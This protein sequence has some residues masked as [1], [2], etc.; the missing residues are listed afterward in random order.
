MSLEWAGLIGILLFLILIFFEIPVGIC[1]GV[2]GFVGLGL[3]RGWDSG[4]SV[5]GLQ[6]YR[7]AAT[8]TFSV[9]P[10]FV[11]MGFLASEIG[12]SAD[13]F[14]AVRNWLGHFKGGLAMATMVACAIFSA[15]CG[16]SIATATTLAAVGLPEMRKQKYSDVLSLGVLAS[17]G[18][19]GFLIPPSLGFVFYAIITE[20]SIGNLFL[21]G[22]GPGILLTAIFLITIAVWCRIDPH[23]GPASAPVNWNKRLISLR[24]IITPAV[25]IVWVL[26]GI[27][28][29]FVTPIEAAAAGTFIIYVI[30]IAMRR[31]TKN[32]FTNSLYETGKLTGRIFILVSGA[33]VLTRFITISELPARLAEMVSS[34]NLPP[35][36]ILWFIMIFYIII[37]FILDIMSIIL[38]VAPVLHFVLVGLGFNPVYLGAITM[39][40]ILMGQISPPFGIV[41]FGLKAFVP[42]VPV[43]TIY[44]GCLPFLGAMLIG[45]AICIHVPA[46]ELFLIPKY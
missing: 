38:I 19:L 15:I 8:Y 11:L 4:F 35:I 27:Y 30:G 45:L 39:I 18:N 25:V 26:G 34:I 29:G 20:Q 12:I 14:I 3:I 44:R 43:W 41:V 2:V 7:T 33:L 36:A 31:L 42:D 22:I 46:I 21:S 9:I 6:Y 24:H 23:L 28:T 32:A 37:G 1:M 10:L 16:D 5:L 40:T 17:G 13:G